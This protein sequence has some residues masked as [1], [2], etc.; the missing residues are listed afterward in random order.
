M[1]EIN[2]NTELM[3]NMELVERLSSRCGISVY[4][5]K[6]EKSGQFYV[7][8]HISIPENQNQVDAL[9]LTGAA[10]DRESAQAY[11]EQVVTDYRE[12][13]EKLEELSASPNVACF[14]SYEIKA[15]EDGVGFDLY[16]LAEHRTTLENHLAANALT[17]SD[18]VNLALDLCTAL[19]ELRA[20]G[21]IHR[22][23]KPGN[24]YLNPQGHFMLGD[25]GIAQIDGLKYCSMPE[26]MISTYSA[27]ELFE[28]MATVNETVDL[29]AVGLILYRVYNGGHA[30]FE[31]EKTSAK[32]ADK[33]RISGQELPA[34]MFADYEIAEIIRKACAYKP[35]DRY[36]T[37]DEM[38]Q[39]FVDYMTRNQVGDAP[40][41]PP[42]F[43]DEITI[44]ALAA[45]EEVVPV[46]FA[47]TE[48]LD[49]TFKQSFSP[50]NDMLNALIESVHKVIDDPAAEDGSGFDTPSQ[51]T[52]NRKR[53]GFTK[54]FPTVILILGITALLAAAVWF[55]FIRKDT[56]TID[57][58]EI[59]DRTV[60][61]ITVSLTTE[62]DPAAFSV[63]C[64]DAYGNVLRQEYV[65][66]EL[67]TFT[68]LAS[69]AQY[70]LSVEGMK[71]ENVAGAV[72]CNASTKSMT[73]IINLSVTRETVSEVELTFIPDGAEPKEWIVSYQAEGED[74]ATKSFVGHTV[75]LTGLKPDTD[76]EIALLDSNDVQ[77]SGST[78]VS[79][80]TLASVNITGVVAEL[81][82]STA[83][84]TWEFEGDAPASW[85]I[86]TTG[87]EGYT[88][89]QTVTENTLVLEDL[90][91]GETYSLII[92]CD[93]M[94]SGASTSFTPDALTITEVTAEV[95]EEGG[96]DISWSCEAEA[97]DVEW[98]VIYTMVGNDQM[99]AV[100]QTAE[101]T[102]TLNSLIPGSKYSI[103]IQEAT[104][105][106]VGGE[107]ITQIEVPAAESFTGYGFTKGYVVMYLR[108]TQEDWT[109]NNLQY[110]RTSFT[111]SEKVAFACQTI[112]ALQDSDDTVTTLLVVRDANG[113]VVDYYT[114]E[115]T[116]NNMWTRDTY[117]GELLRTP[118]EPGSYTLELYFN[119]NRVKTD[120]DIG[121]TITQ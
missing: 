47:D 119:G 95:N 91:G 51:S 109:V 76:Y 66:G 54:W 1:T 96:M 117:V 87:S 17:Q 80:H 33:L 116:W 70:V 43:A 60:D 68:G 92:T 21:L 102:V 45:E 120:S 16:L 113:S 94:V 89:N 74:P 97:E 34:P 29:Y 81:S 46:Q 36:Q 26:R 115:E 100:E 53:T 44:D 59:T 83:V 5:V 18:A 107:N 69:G 19:S 118:E 62:E 108:P 103:E 14:R 4:T 114:G 77:L 61:S 12:E 99:K 22:D 25:L 41:T 111:G 8:K 86:T 65:P 90:K 39:A 38:K 104:G 112:S 105:E 40:I 50:D 72:P 49:E 11:Y 67:N 88:D 75:V 58:V 30:P 63:I 9:I 79:A 48:D 15:K 31:D 121:F 7:L 20:A 37:P 27:P 28:L 64:T 13:L 35:E 2:L 82:K 52:K 101:Q 110:N 57:S 24:I 73:N 85:N 106:Q 10:A 84:I 42:I 56:L 3:T 55:F 71:E 98:M 32:G 93:N 6:S 78:A 23:V